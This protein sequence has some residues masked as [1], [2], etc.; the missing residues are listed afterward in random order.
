[1][2]NYVVFQSVSKNFQAPMN[3][4]RAISYKS[5]RLLG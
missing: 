3:S 1:M 2:P 4:D 5:K